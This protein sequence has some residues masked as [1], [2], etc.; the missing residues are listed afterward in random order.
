MEESLSRCGQA[1]RFCWERQYQS[2][3]EDGIQ[4]TRKMTTRLKE[5]VYSTYIVQGRS[6]ES[7]S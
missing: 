1:L 5:D 6:T 4:K 2:C 3:G 7:E